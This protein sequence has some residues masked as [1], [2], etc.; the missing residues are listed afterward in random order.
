LDSGRRRGRRG[1]R[2]PVRRQG[3]HH[4][5]RFDESIA[6]TRRAAELDPQNPQVPIDGI[7]ATTWKGD[8]AAAR[9]LVRRSAELDPTF[10]FPPFVRWPAAGA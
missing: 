1:L 5:G 7:F 9:R 3:P 10:F 8:V 4:Q 2:A 6:E